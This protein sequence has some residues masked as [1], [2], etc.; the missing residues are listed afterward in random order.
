MIGGNSSVLDEFFLG[1]SASVEPSPDVVP[2]EGEGCLTLQGGSLTALL[3]QVASA[4]VAAHPVQVIGV[5]VS[6]SMES[7][8]PGSSVVLADQQLFSVGFFVDSMLAARERLAHLKA[9]RFIPEG[10]ELRIARAL[11]VLNAPAPSFFAD[12]ETWKW[13][14]QDADIE[15]L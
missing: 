11:Q 10:R 7:T 15:D 13:A 12:S 9:K 2:A 6:S 14:A 5:E 1:S 3:R 4:L 8:D